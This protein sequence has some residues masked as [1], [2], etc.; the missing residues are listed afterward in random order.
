M[1]ETELQALAILTN[2]PH[3]LYEGVIYVQTEGEA[4]DLD[5]PLCTGCSFTDRHGRAGSDEYQKFRTP[6][7]VL[8]GASS[9]FRMC[10]NSESRFKRPI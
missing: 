1:N 10:D 3:A 7:L 8:Y 5:A 9:H 4:Q 2:A 6:E